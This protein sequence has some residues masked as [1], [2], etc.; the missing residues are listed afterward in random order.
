M[1]QVLEKILLELLLDQYIKIFDRLLFHLS[2]L[3]LLYFKAH[4]KQTNFHALR[5]HIYYLQTLF[6]SKEKRNLHNI[7]QN[8][9]ILTLQESCQS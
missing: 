6:F 9:E 8:L 4:L 1:C 7:F 5:E 2:L 3:G